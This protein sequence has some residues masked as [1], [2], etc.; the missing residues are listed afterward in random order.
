MKRLLGICSIFLLTFFLQVQIAK[1]DVWGAAYGAAIAKRA[2]DTAYEEMQAAI[3]GTLKVT[4]YEL[5]H[6]QVGQL[7]GGT[8]VKESFIISDWEDFI[9]RQPMDR[10][11]VYMNDFFS[12]S[13]QAKNSCDYIPLMSSSAG[14]PFQDSLTTS[15]ASLQEGVRFVQNFPSYLEE[16]ARATIGGEISKGVDKVQEY[17][18]DQ[19]C[20]DP[21]EMFAS[22]N[23]KCWDAYFSNDFN[24]PYGYSLLAEKKYYT[25]IEKNREIARLQSTAYQGYKPQTTGDGLYVIT[26][27][28]LIKDIQS[29]VTDLGNKIIAAANSPSEFFSALITSF[30]TSFIQQTV[31]NGVGEIQQHIQTEIREADKKMS[32]EVNRVVEEVG[33]RARYMPL[34]QSDNQEWKDY[35]KGN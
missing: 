31:R 33:L 28:S 9:V 22:G 7:I 8:S 18:L 16:Y 3:L 5:L 26:P 1:A 27:G 2:M 21:S 10:S 34:Y 11:V 25:E 20:S 14:D 32:T 29:S 24:N 15:C 12:A 13:F 35:Y 23:W 17:T 19:F 30:V 6:T 4:A